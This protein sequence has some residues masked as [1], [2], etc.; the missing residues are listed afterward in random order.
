[1]ERFDYVIVT[2]ENTWESTGASATQKELDSDIAEV[3]ERLGLNDAGEPVKLFIFKAS[4]LES[5]AC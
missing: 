1:M 2:E 5:F 4:V 3:K